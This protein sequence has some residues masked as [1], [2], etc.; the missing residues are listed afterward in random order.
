MT[1]LLTKSH[2]MGIAA[3]VIYDLSP[4]NIPRNADHILS[5]ANRFFI[6]AT[7]GKEHYEKFYSDLRHETT[8]EKVIMLK[9]TAIRRT[10]GIP[11]PSDISGIAVAGKEIVV[12]ESILQYRIENPIDNTDDSAYIAADYTSRIPTEFN[13]EAIN[14]DNK[15]TFHKYMD[16]FYLE[17]TDT[18]DLYNLLNNMFQCIPEFNELNLSELEIQ[19]S[20]GLDDPNRPKYSFSSAYDVIGDEDWKDNF[21]DLTAFIQNMMYL[22]RIDAEEEDCFNAGHQEVIPEI[23]PNET[24][25][26]SGI[27]MPKG[28]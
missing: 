9:D 27:H 10:P 3:R 1:R 16:M 6:E 5:E 11:E 28:E 19:H 17:Y 15:I 14:P 22:I 25:E 4:R 24:G 7:L 20:V 2:F 13:M 26:V 23:N 12:K 18:K 21:V 8:P